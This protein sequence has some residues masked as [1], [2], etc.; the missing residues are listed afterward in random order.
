[1]SLR[2]HSVPPNPSKHWGATG[3]NTPS[4]P[5]AQKYPMGMLQEMRGELI[6]P[7]GCPGQCLGGQVPM[8]DVVPRCACI[9]CP[10]TWACTC[11]R[12]HRGHHE[13]PGDAAP[14]GSW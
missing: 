4:I 2:D 12:R 1:M 7:T 6:T 11:Q 5:V 14:W 8:G 3:A 9:S 13:P 10:A